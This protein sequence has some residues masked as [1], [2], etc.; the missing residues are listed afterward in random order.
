MAEAPPKFAKGKKIG[1][2]FLSLRS[3]L[4]LGLSKNIIYYNLSV[5]VHKSL[6]YDVMSVI[7]LLFSYFNL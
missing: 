3:A 4:P 1:H 6:M 5:A 7:I 2:S